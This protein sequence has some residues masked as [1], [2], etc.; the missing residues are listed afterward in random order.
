LVWKSPPPPKKNALTKILAAAEYEQIVTIL[1]ARKIYFSIQRGDGMSL[2]IF[3]YADLT[4]S[5]YELHLG[6]NSGG[7]DIGPIMESLIMTSKEF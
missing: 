3:S 2:S 7:P 1:P 4:S 6:S 5:D